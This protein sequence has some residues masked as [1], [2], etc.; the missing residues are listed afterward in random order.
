MENKLLFLY[1]KETP[2]GL[3]Y[4]GTTSRNPFRYKGSGK[5]WLRVVRKY[6]Y[7]AR[8]IKTTILFETHSREELREKGLYYSKLWNVVNDI[9]WAN[10]IPESGESST[11][12]ATV[13]E[14]TKQ[15]YLPKIL[16]RVMRL[17]D[18]LIYDSVNQAAR[19]NSIYP[20]HLRHRLNLNDVS[21]GFRYID[22]VL[23]EKAKN[24]EHVKFIKQNLRNVKN[25]PKTSSCIGVSWNK[26]KNVWVSQIRINGKK[27]FLGY[28]NN[29]IDAHNI[30]QEKLNIIKNA[31]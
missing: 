18:N 8:T 14:E 5:Y 6:K 26:E 29:E 22:S 16:H 21:I 17:S 12:G 24:T 23:Q 27:S 15:K 19:E 25:I 13:S 2:C 1:I 11:I 30:Y 31:K 9:F 7:R 20:S 28:F 3:K 10:L 4:L